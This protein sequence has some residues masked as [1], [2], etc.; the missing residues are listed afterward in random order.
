MTMPA[1]NR[2]GVRLHRSTATSR[3]RDAIRPDFCEG[4]TVL[5]ERESRW[6]A[7]LLGAREAPNVEADTVEDLV[8]A[9][10]EWGG[11]V[12]AIEL[13]VKVCAGAGGAGE[14]EEGVERGVVAI[15]D[16]AAAEV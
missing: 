6:R 7:R 13:E 4:Y 1:L 15:G 2:P 12:S 16:V 14:T 3:S 9:E 8:E 5:R 10:V 11:L